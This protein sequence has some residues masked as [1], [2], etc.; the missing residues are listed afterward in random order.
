MSPLQTSLDSSQKVREFVREGFAPRFGRVREQFRTEPRWRR[1]AELGT[2]LW[3]DTGD[4]DDAGGLWTREFNALTTNNTLLNK[5]VQKGQY[6]ALIAESARMLADFGLKPPEALLE[7]AFI[8]NARHGLKLVEQFDATVSVEEHTDLAHDLPRAVAYA[9][10]YHQVCPER[11]VVKLPFTPAGLL[12]TRILSQEGIA[13]NHTLGFSARQNY[14][15][16]RIGRPEFVNVFLGRLSSAVV[17]NKLGDGRYVGERATVASQLA[18]RHLRDT[19]QLPT[20]QIGASFREAQQVLDLAGID[21]MTMPPKVAEGFLG[22][23][24]GDAEIVD[25]SARHYACE[26]DPSIDVEALGILSLWNIDRDLIAC[27][28]D[29]EQ[30]NLDAFTPEDLV[31][32]FAEHGCGDFLPRWT[33]EQQDVSYQE[34]KIPNLG[35]WRDALHGGFC[36]MDSLMNLAGLSSFKADQKA[37]D[38]RVRDVMA[39]KV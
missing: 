5:E 2:E 38:D 25:R 12:A 11:F 35:H 6:D 1:M 23:P 27:V 29:L 36:A 33:S 21:V 20:R 19:R 3:L 22:L 16:A 17:D 39:R 10:R 7:I 30:E 28:D 13:I 14:V 8:L 37:M 15:I 31:Q 24:L 4:L 9:R 18:I 34:G 32:F 26:F